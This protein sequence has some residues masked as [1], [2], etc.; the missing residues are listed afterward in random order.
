LTNP[1]NSRRHW[2]AVWASSRTWRTKTADVALVAMVKASGKVGLRRV[3]EIHDPA[4]PRR[5]TFRA[6]VARRFDDEGLI[7]ACKPIRDA[8][9]PPML[10][11]RR[12]RMVG[13]AGAEMIHS[14]G[15][16]S[17][18]EFRYEQ[19]VDRAN[20]GVEITAEAIRNAPR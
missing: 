20:P 10:S 12:G 7:A 13:A 15:P 4:R 16:D 9:C 14:D 11:W 3:I 5:I 8:L 17:G 6:H 1:L 18:H 19:I 2:R